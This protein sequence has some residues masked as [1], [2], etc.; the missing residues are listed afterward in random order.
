MKHFKAYRWFC[1]EKI[2]SW[3]QNMQFILELKVLTQEKLI[4]M[5]FF[6]SFWHHGP[7]ISSHK[8]ID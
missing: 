1:K 4:F 5:V 3:E 2:K 6:F 8:P 7:D